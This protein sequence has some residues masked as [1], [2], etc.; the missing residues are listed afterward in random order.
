MTHDSAAVPPV[1]QFLAALRAR[2]VE[3]VRALLTTH[4]AVRAAVNAPLASFDGRPLSMVKTTLPL[5]DLLLEYGANLNLKSAWWAGGFG[6]L[7]YDI[8]P[9]QAAPLIER[10]AIVDVWAAAHLGMLERLRALVDG[11]ATLVDARGGDGRTPLHCARTV[12]VATYLLEHGAAIDARDVDHESTPAQHLAREAPDV[13]RLLIDRGAWFDIFLAVALRDPALVE[14]CL[15]DDPESLDHRTWHGKY[16]VAH[17]GRRAATQAEIGD[18]RGDIYRWVFGHN[19]SALDVALHLGFDDIADL[20]RRRATPAQQLLSLVARADGAAARAL[21]A[22]HPGVVAALSTEQM[23]LLADRAHADDTAAV[24]LMLDLGFDPHAT[25]P[26]DAEAIRWA[27]FHGNAALVRRLLQHDPPIGVR[28]SKFH[29]TLLG[30]CLY[31]SREGW[32][33]TAGDFAATVQLLLEA[34]E[35]PDATMVAT[36]RE[37]VDAVLRAWAQR[38]SRS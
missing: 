2:D 29:S 25:G 30:W 31:G 6:L 33:C 28:D 11:D 18:R 35:R 36:G 21:V 14:R 27:A 5:V 24:A 20:L 4:A 10:G 37:D 7:E 32:R 23:R 15:R 12:A 38:H 3:R 19:V 17:D 1:E 13:A 26:E 8:T 9:A 16:V 22:A 34:G